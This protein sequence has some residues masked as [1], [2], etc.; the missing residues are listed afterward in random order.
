MD[1]FITHG[2]VSHIDHNTIVYERLKSHDVKRRMKTRQK[3]CDE[4]LV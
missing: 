3:I 1:V 2:I 4:K